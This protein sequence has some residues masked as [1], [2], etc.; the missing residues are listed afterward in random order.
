MSDEGHD[1]FR[2][3]LRSCTVKF[4]R[5]AK[6]HTSWLSPDQGTSRQS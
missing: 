2:E 5:E 3:R 4:L 1:T 6:V